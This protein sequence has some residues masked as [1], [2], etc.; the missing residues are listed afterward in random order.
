MKPF[1]TVMSIA[2][3]FA[4]GVFA[5]NQYTVTYS[6]Q[7][8]NPPGGQ[9]NYLNLDRDDLSILISPAN[10]RFEYFGKSFDG[11]KVGS[12]GYI[13]MGPSGATTS[14][15]PDHGA[16]PGLVIA[17]FWTDLMPNTG[18]DT[19]VYWTWDQ[20]NLTVTWQNVIQF[21]SG[22][23][24][25]TPMVNM[26]LVL[27]TTTGIIRFQYGQPSGQTQVGGA[28]SSVDHCVA[29][30]DDLSV[31]PQPLII[32]EIP[33]YISST[34]Q[35]TTYPADHEIVFS[36]SGTP[37]IPPAFTSSPVLHAEDGQLYT[38]TITTTGTPAPTLTAPTLPGWLNLNGNV[39]SGTPDNSHV[40]IPQGVSLM[41][42]N[43]AGS[44]TQ[45][46]DITVHPFQP[47]PTSPPDI[48]S[49]PVTTATVG[50]FYTYDITA[51]GDPTPTISVSN[52]PAWLT[53]TGNTLEGTPG[54]GDVGTTGTITV[55]ATN[56]EGTDTQN[57]TIDVLPAPEAPEITSSAPTTA[58][59]GSSY[60]Y[61]IVA[62]G[63]PAP[64]F[65]VSGNPGWL[66]LSG[67]LLSGTPGAGDAGT[68]GTITVTATNSEGTDTESFTITVSSVPEAPA[69]TSTPG[70][71]A[72]VND[73]YTY[74]VTATG[75]PA[76]TI[77]FSNLPG[78]L[79]QSG[80]TISGTP[81]AADAGL[82][83][84]ITVTATNNEGTDTQNFTIDVTVPP[85]GGG[86]GSN[87]GGCT[88]NSGLTGLLILTLMSAA[89]L[90]WRRRE[91]CTA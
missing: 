4:A 14:P 45:N 77:T 28:T 13:I 34:G 65:S 78:W 8:Y 60:S 37:A 51:T 73:T 6:Q 21:T 24:I 22:A 90:V 71:E 86:S 76:P 89:L 26:T 38:Y 49:T 11:F 61:Q 47:S 87:G 44:V 29:I 70:T 41:A 19:Y 68:T 62:T 42:T 35:V 40:G 32:G 18:V 80:N 43:S 3:L 48:T 85:I 72:T 52:N 46:F 16:T 57:F 36:P 31:D 63:N 81:S 33:N 7:A 55:T 1:I 88:A 69:I 83:G 30:S 17:P 66:T 67:D 79:S 15:R 10:F 58:L 23:S 54:A 53:Q 75:Y 5:Q 56:S 2:C 9:A 64:T 74:S 82:T 91:K 84:T 25:F 12:N 50:D 20:S 59:V 39:L 27:E